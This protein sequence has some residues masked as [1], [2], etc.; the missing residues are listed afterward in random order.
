MIV[1]CDK[2]P[3]DVNV[4]A[5][6]PF[7][8]IKCGYIQDAENENHENIHYAQEKALGLILFLLLYGIEYLIRL[9]QYRDH[10]RAYYNISFESE[11]YSNQANLD[12]L[13]ERKLWE[14]LSYYA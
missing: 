3:F 9:I 8:F 5:L 11:A 4:I 7:M 10:W 12:Y 14:F 13:Q 2:L 6:Y 1:R